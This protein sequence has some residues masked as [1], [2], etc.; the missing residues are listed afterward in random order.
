MPAR[1]SDSVYTRTLLS[2]V[3]RP[4][5][6]RRPL[7]M[8]LAAV[9]ALALFAQEGTGARG[10]D[11]G[12][13]RVSFSPGAGLDFVDPALSFT[14]PGW[15]LLDATCARLFTY[16]DKAPPAGFRLQP[17]V[18]ASWKA[19]NDLKTY[20]FTLRPGFRFNDGKPVH[21]S[22]FA[23]AINRVLQPFVRSPGAIYAQDIVGA[24]DVLAGRTGT[25]RG[26]IARAN[27]LV[28]R[29]TRPTPDFLARTSLPFFCAVPPGLPASGEGM[30]AFPSAGPY[31]V[32]EYRANERIVIRRN[33]HYG[34]NR[35]VHL[36]GFD[37]N[38]RGGSPSELLRSID[39]G[40][41]DWG[42]M[43]SGVFLD[44]TLDLVR[45]HGI[46]QSR[47]FVR[48]GLGLRMLAFNSS[49]P[50]FRNNPR[51][52]R[53]INFAL[54]REELIATSGGPVVAS[55]TD[56]HLPPGMP[57][58]RDAKIYPPKGDLARARQLAQGHLRSGKAVLYTTGTNPLPIQAAQVA[59]RQ[60]SRIGLEVRV[61]L[62]P[63]H[64]TSVN[65]LERLTARGADWDIALVLWTPNLPD[66]HA[67][68]NLLIESQLIGGE[69]LPRLR[70]RLARAELG[71][72]VRLPQGR[73]RERAYAEV[74]ATLAREVAPVAPLN[75]VHE[76]TLVSERVGC[77]VLR[78]VLDLAVACLK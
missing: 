2:A 53:A 18:A 16:P 70:S 62:I 26:V 76:A 13:L 51:L 58:F 33:P 12:I 23:H 56:Q 59:A 48:P 55:V 64:V 10:Q 61:E 41:A 44:P 66:A 73:A 38:L 36:D 34:G 37:V 60:L 40:D 6:L 72:A 9:C 21:A 74:D 78:P 49:R 35:R 20:T 5:S 7:L 39:R 27:T 15:S 52:R 3:S 57:G 50:L 4:A 8:G 29:F 14:Q 63:E 17:E 1:L 30:G 43:I 22:A 25:A 54:D 28:V 42:H 71:R 75:V 68:L 45:K 46:N 31:F 69:T 47:F 11:G 77:I 67:Y 19:S 24:G 65:Y 32:Q